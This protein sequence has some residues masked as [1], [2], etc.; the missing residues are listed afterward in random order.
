MYD[1]RLLGA[2]DC[3][4]T[5]G[6]IAARKRIHTPPI[7]FE[8]YHAGARLLDHGAML[9]HARDHH[10]VETQLPS[11]PRHRQKVRRE[12]PILGD[13]ENDLASEAKG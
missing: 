2:Q 13:E 1:R 4:E 11:G 3:C 12:E 6:S 5:A 8:G 9:T 10:D 7:G